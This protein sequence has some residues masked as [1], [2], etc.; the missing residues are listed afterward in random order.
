MQCR[1]GTGIVCVLLTI[2]NQIE[3][4]PLMSGKKGDGKKKM[5]SLGYNQN[6]SNK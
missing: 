1:I 4:Q 6:T 3:E 2:A 5:T